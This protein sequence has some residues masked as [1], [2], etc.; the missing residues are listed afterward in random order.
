MAS[1]DKPQKL[2]VHHFQEY[3]YLSAN[4][5]GIVGLVLYKVDADQG[6]E[7]HVINNSMARGKARNAWLEVGARGQ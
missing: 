1:L 5:R 2:S 3:L 6:W 7:A 4:I